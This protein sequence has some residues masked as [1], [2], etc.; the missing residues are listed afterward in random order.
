[1]FQYKTRFNSVV[2]AS[3]NF[4]NNVLLSQASL[5][6]LKNLIPDTVNLE[7]NID[8]VGAAFNAAVV[9]KFNKNGDGI[10]TNSAI[11]FKKFFIH[12]PTNIEHKKRNIVGHIVNAGFSSFENNKILTDEDVKNSLNPFNISLAAVV[13]KT[14]D[15]DFANALIESNNPDSDFYRQVSASWEIGFNDFFVAVGSENLEEA[16]IITDAKKIK[17][18]KKYLRGFDGA[19]EM[20]DGTPVF[21]LVTGRIYPLGI[22]F[23]TNPAAEVEGVITDDAEKY[24][25]KEKNIEKSESICVNSLELL[26]N[27]KIFSQ[28]EKSNVNIN[29]TNI[30]DLEQLLKELQELN[31][32]LSEKKGTDTF[33]EE[34]AANISHKI[35]ESI[36][37]KSDEIQAKIV[38]AEEA[39]AKAIAEATKLK[40]DFDE[41]NTKLDEALSKI[42]EL[43]STLSA[44]AAQELFNSRMGILDEEYNFE[45]VDRKFLVEELK[46]LDASDEAFS[47]FQEKIS[48]LYRHKT[49]AYEEEQNKLFQ[50]KLEVEL[51]KKFQNEKLQVSNASD[52]VVNSQATEPQK[53]STPEAE[54]EVETAL[55]NAEEQTTNIPAQNIATQSEKSWKEK[56]GQAFSKEN[57]LINY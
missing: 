50:E 56:M 34:A 39:K 29:K 23:T 8:L 3:S 54:V 42:N 53:N 35:A 33:S 48:V 1:M 32:V 13:Y 40:E 36:K 44:Q 17:E 52:A 20:E 21:R 46:N 7:E 55:A 25:Q 37:E 49:K 28:N 10:D 51:A 57:I 45:D 47:S 24:E 38:S 14:V 15:K 41:Q 18:F 27:N 30:M 11:A 31:R 16:E 5:E 2:T 4:E 9:N 6:P 26:K 19:G 12:K 22:G 43:E